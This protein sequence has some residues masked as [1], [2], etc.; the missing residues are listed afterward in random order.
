MMARYLKDGGKIDIAKRW[1]RVQ[2][3]EHVVMFD[4]D[5]EWGCSVLSGVKV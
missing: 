5:I 2:H 1:K 4:G 3:Q